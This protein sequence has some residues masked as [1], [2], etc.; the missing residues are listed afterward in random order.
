MKLSV[1]NSIACLETARNA[2]RKWLKRK[3]V[4][5][6]LSNK[7]VLALDEALT[8]III[9]GFKYNPNGTINVEFLR[10]NN[11]ICLIIEDNGKYYDITKIKPPAPLTLMR[12]GKT[13]G[14]GI[15]IIKVVMDEVK[16]IYSEKDKTNK[17][18]LIKYI[19]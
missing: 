4:L 6:K 8:N 9:H 19:K 18:I 3:K 10:E 1:G 13:H 14:F 15:Y 7:I 12:K 2:L 11:K 16:Y 17:L 5:D